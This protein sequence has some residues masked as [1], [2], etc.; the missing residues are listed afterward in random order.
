MTTRTM[1]SAPPLWQT[2]SAP[3]GAPTQGCTAPGIV[4][5]QAC[6]ARIRGG[7]P[8]RSCGLSCGGWTRAGHAVADHGLHLS[9]TSWRAKGF[10]IC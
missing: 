10:A 8:W 1:R 3:A 2:W 7:P 9:R 6:R 5:R 4:R